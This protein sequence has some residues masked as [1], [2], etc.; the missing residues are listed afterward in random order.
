MRR[1]T[2]NERRKGVS[3]DMNRHIAIDGPAGSGKSTV[4]RAVA[5]KM[6]LIYVD[7][8]AMYRAMAV[9][10]VRLGLGASDEAGIAAACESASVTI[11]Y[12]AGEQQVYLNGENITGLLRAEQTGRMASACSVYAPVRDKM[13]RLQK[14]LA[15]ESSVVMD[16]R[17]IGTVVLPDAFLKVYLTASR[18]VRA[19]RRYE[20]LR[21]KGQRINLTA[22]EEEMRI[23]DER[24]MNRA[25]AP[26]RQAED[27]LLLDTS[28]LT[29]Q[30][31]TDTICRLYREKM[32]K[33]GAPAWK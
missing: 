13:G 30:E 14:E 33:E 23:R 27:A 25:I 28:G 29:P 32:E 22:V 11:G 31:A 3:S 8:G 2:R 26:L 5:A 21:A 19:G 24:D 17:D 1:R 18:T 10:F 9:H 7:T 12:E 16:G 20:E 15:A 6:G 4:A